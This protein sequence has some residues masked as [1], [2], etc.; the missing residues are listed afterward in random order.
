MESVVLH[1]MDCNILDSKEGDIGKHTSKPET[2]EAELMASLILTSI[3]LMNV[4]KV[5]SGN[6]NAVISFVQALL[7][8][9]SLSNSFLQ[10]ESIF[11]N[12]AENALVSTHYGCY[13][14]PC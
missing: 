14:I 5:N 12:A 10:L 4:F 13:K 1:T 3:A 11:H 7:K 9:E 6:D 2:T 8:K